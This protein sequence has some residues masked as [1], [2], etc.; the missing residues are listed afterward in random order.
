MV[1]GPQLGLDPLDRRFDVL[2]A[3]HVADEP[4]DVVPFRDETVHRA[5]EAVAVPVDCGDP[6]T[7]LPQCPDHGCT[8]SAGCPRD[9]GDLSLHGSDLL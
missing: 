4:V 6:G 3:C 7:T 5:P 1:H 8:D 9:Q 2:A